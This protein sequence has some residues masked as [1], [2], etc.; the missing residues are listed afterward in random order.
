MMKIT[1]SRMTLK[2]ARPFRTSKA[3]RTDKETIWVIVHDD[4]QQGSGEVVPMDTYRQTLDSAEL[5]LSKIAARH[6]RDAEELGSAIEELTDEFRDQLATVAGLDAAFLDWQGKKKRM[7]TWRALG[8]TDPSVPLTSF[9]L[10]I[11]SD[12]S[13]LAEHVRSA[14]S[15]PILKIKL[16]TEQDERILDTIR[17]E[18]PTAIIR[19]DANMAW[20]VDEALRKLP[21]LAKYDVEFVEQPLAA[22][23][24]DGLRKLKRAG[25]LPIVA[26]ESCVR[27]D[28]VDR[29]AGHVDGINIKLSKC[30]GIRQGLEMIRRARDAGLRIM[31]GCMVES[32]LGIAAALQLAPLVDWLDLDG[33]LLLTADPFS[34]IGGDQGVLR[35]STEPG[36]G[37]IPKQF[38]S[39]EP[40][41]GS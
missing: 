32:S 19:V 36:L 39:L 16:G 1:W 28:D 41:V 10:G 20:S 24:L 23:D 11:E 25:I 3:V 14:A 8:V 18:A 15:F 4:G 2:M 35:L 30:G 34:G 29:L 33:H 21:M 38:R 5:T 27:P 6:F 7:P 31:L 13:A 40:S 12:L 26:D 17:R 37:V 22:D 9:T